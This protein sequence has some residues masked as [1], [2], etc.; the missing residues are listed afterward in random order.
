MKTNSGVSLTAVAPTQ[1]QVSMFFEDC[2]ICREKF[3]RFQLNSLLDWKFFIG[4][5]LKCTQQALTTTNTPANSTKT[6]KIKTEM[7]RMEECR[8]G[9]WGNYFVLQITYFF[10]QQQL[11]HDMQSEISVV[12]VTLSIDWDTNN[13]Y[14]GKRE[15]GRR[16]KKTA[17]RRSNVRYMTFPVDPPPFTKDARCSKTADRTELFSFLREVW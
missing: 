2:L 14:R 17:T 16:P 5:D 7:E 4:Q 6:E 9:Y 1:P 11:Q 12:F 13:L 10:K 15:G 8:K 3:A